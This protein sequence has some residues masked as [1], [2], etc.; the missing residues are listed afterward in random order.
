[1]RREQPPDGA[2]AFRPLKRCTERTTYGGSSSLQAAEI[3]RERFTGPLG[4]DA[5]AKRNFLATAFKRA[6]DSPTTPLVALPPP[7]LP[8]SGA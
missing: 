7:S 2:A 3:V 8:E 1:M 6:C 4:P 5:P